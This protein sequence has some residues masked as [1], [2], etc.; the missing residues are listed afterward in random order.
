M[1]PASV[2]PM[3]W[4]RG[5]LNLSRNSRCSEGESGADEERRKRMRRKAA[6]AAIRVGDL[7]SPG[8]AR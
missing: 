6:L 2:D 8:A 4:I 7:S 1:L 3:A 5:K